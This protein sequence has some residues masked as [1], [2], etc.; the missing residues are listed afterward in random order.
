M[1]RN[2]N[3][4]ENDFNGRRKYSIIVSATFTRYVWCRQGTESN[5]SVNDQINSHVNVC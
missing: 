1:K 5:W 3:V 2:G 4:T